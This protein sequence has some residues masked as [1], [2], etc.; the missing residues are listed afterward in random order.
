MILRLQYDLHSRI[1]QDYYQFRFL[2]MF[3]QPFSWILNK[4]QEDTSNPV[5]SCYFGVSGIVH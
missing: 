1:V 2:D 4:K 3:W 5:Q